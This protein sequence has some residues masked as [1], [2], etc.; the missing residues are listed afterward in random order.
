MILKKL[1]T[2]L[3]KRE[4]YKR[5][6]SQIAQEFFTNTNS[7]VDDKI[8]E[9]FLI[10]TEK[11]QKIL[12]DYAIKKKLSN[13]GI[14]RIL[15]VARTIADLENSQEINQNHLLEAIGYRRNL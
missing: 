5:Y 8:I 10:I 1:E 3:F 2:E 15:R 12:Q 9:K 13:R 6:E 14:S 11:L 4:I 7:E